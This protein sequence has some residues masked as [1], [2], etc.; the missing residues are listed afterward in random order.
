MAN[1]MTLIGS[2]TV[3]ASPV[4]SITFA[5]IPSTYTDLLLKTSLRDGTGG[6]TQTAQLIYFNSDNGTSS[7]SYTY[8]RG[9]GSAASSA[10]GNPGGYT[11]AYIG[12]Y[13]GSAATTNTF[14]NSEI[15]IPNY[16]GSQK[17]SF[18][19]D[20]VQETNATA[21]YSHLVAGLWSAA[22]GTAAIN[23]IT[24]TPVSGAG[25]NFVQYSTAYLYG[26]K[27]S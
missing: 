5:S 2:V 3:G 19:V 11:G 1:T 9:S 10:A 4:T 16:A 22:G 26:I 17:K 23:A 14:S 18:S 8:L 25:A 24:F 7:W 27:N 12:E 21:A 15:Y 6:G 20:A 13:D